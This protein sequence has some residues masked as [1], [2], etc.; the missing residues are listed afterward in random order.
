ML[1]AEG[2]CFVAIEL[3]FLSGVLGMSRLIKSAFTASAQELSGVRESYLIYFALGFVAAQVCVSGWSIFR[4]LERTGTGDSELVG[5]VGSGFQA[6]KASSPAGKPVVRLAGLL[7]CSASSNVGH[8][9]V[10]SYIISNLS[11]VVSQSKLV[12]DHSLP[13][14]RVLWW[15]CVYAGVS[16]L[17]L[18]LV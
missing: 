10:H 15:A 14:I 8:A 18:E 1:C 2:F 6:G 17:T 16:V 7:L 9:C 12:L 5:V 4:F 3:S 13:G 11:L